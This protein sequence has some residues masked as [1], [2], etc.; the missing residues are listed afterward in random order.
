MLM[1]L[2]FFTRSEN[3]FSG[4]YALREV[5]WFGRSSC[6]DPNGFF[7]NQKPWITQE[8]WYET[9]RGLTRSAQQVD[10]MDLILKKE[11][12]WLY[13]PD[14]DK[15]GAIDS[16]KSIPNRKGTPGNYW[17][18]SEYCSGFAIDERCEWRVEEMDL[19]RF[20]PAQ[21]QTDLSLNCDQLVT[22]A[23][24]KVKLESQEQAMLQFFTT[25]FT[26]GVLTIASLKFSSDIEGIVIIPIKKIVDIIQRL[27]EG[28]LKK[29]DPPKLNT[30]N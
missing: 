14:F 21:C 6:T 5:F 9:L 20:T 16:I 28:P 26:C 18:Q 27:A 29:T 12:L 30:N 11:L 25:I 13:A 23:R 19:V 22:Y 8:G 4:E 24:F 15:N 1:I 3:D 7:C 17:E 10:G 2:P